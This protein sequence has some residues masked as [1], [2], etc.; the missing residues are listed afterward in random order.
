M[1]A[2]KRFGMR[3]TIEE[4]EMLKDLANNYNRTQSSTLKSIIRDTWRVLELEEIS[5]ESVSDLDTIDSQE[6]GKGPNNK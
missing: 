1:K 6:Y 2:T 4:V 3:M 5:K